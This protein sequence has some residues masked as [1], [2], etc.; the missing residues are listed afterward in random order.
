MSQLIPL[1]PLE[2]V[3][4]PGAPLPLH[5]FE[6][7]YKE[8]IGEVMSQNDQFGLVRLLNNNSIAEVGCTAEILEVTKKYEDGR[9]DIVTAGAKAL[10][11]HAPRPGASFLRAEVAVLRGRAGERGEGGTG[12][13]NRSP[14]ATGRSSR[15]LKP[16]RSN[17]TIR[18]SRFNWPEA[19]RSIW[20]SNRRCWGCGRKS[21]A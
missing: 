16:P 1:F 11:D 14:Q 12:T 20:I 4:L 6:P 17:W 18:S 10:R 19:C 15:Q 7:R 3:L 2:L 5:I 21:S 9:M 13:A 8:M